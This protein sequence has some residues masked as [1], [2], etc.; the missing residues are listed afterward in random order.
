MLTLV[1]DRLGVSRRGRATRVLDASARFTQARSAVS[2]RSR[3]IAPSEPVKTVLW[4]GAE[5]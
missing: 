2:V 4:V 5:G 3:S 1:D